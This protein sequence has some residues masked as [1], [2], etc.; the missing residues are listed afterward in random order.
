MVC[1]LHAVSIAVFPFVF[2]PFVVHHALPSSQVASLLD[3]A[4]RNHE[5]VAFEILPDA[6]DAARTQL[7]ES[8]RFL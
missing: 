5:R 3:H 1:G 2:G 4:F 8:E 7:H 6:R